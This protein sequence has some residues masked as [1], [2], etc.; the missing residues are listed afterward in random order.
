MNSFQERVREFNEF[1][2]R[3]PKLG[4]Y[5]EYKIKEQMKMKKALKIKQAQKT[6]KSKSPSLY[7]RSFRH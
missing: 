6:M 7:L 4:Y 5:E 1:E 2:K 3:V